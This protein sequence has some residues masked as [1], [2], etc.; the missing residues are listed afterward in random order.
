MFPRDEQFVTHSTARGLR[1]S[2]YRAADLHVHPCSCDTIPHRR[3]LPDNLLRRAEEVGLDYVAFSDHNDIPT[4]DHRSSSLVPA[5]EFDVFDT[6]FVGHTVHE[7][8]YGLD[9]VNF[10]ELSVL[11]SSGDLRSF[12][13]YCNV[14]GLWLCYAHPLWVREGERLNAEAVPRVA[15][16][17]HFIEVNGTVSYPQNRAAHR[18]ARALGMPE[19]ANSDTHTAHLGET[20]TL[21]RGDTFAEW[22]QN[23]RR[24][25]YYLVVEH[26]TRKTFLEELRRWHDLVFH[27]E[28]QDAG[29]RDVLRRR[30][31]TKIPPLDAL[32]RSAI[33]GGLSRRPVLKALVG[34]AVKLLFETRLADLYVQSESEY[35]LRGDPAMGDEVALRAAAREAILYSAPTP[36][37]RART[38]RNVTKTLMEAK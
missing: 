23:V 12:A 34:R 27:F 4:H 11:A 19:L 29:F 14:N 31:C 36:V 35:G 8:V 30:R 10:E 26:L 15:S 5:V 37:R 38:V 3:L 16:L 13:A 9:R 1:R 33:G 21:A 17:N 20:F 7:L 32:I 22:I 18:L 25:D 6:E 28:P 24:G 2:G